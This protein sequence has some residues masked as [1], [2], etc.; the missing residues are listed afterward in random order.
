MLPAILSYPSILASITTA[1]LPTGVISIHLTAS[2]HDIVSYTTIWLDLLQPLDIFYSNDRLPSSSTTWVK[3]LSSTQN[4]IDPWSRRHYI[5]GPQPVNVRKTFKH[6][7][8]GNLWTMAPLDFVPLGL[9]ILCTLPIFIATIWKRNPCSRGD[10]EESEKPYED[11]DG[12]ATE[13]SAKTFANKLT[14]HLILGSTLSGFVL[15]TVI[16]V[17]DTAGTRIND[18]LHSWLTF[19]CW[20]KTSYSSLYS[21]GQH[22]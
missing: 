18:T 12:S 22:D 4:N 13:A 9:I 8:H 15:S 16:A 1:E 21:S 11:E 6:R 7:A 2:T 5:S 19:C 10:F 3:P 20:V 14:I 17:H